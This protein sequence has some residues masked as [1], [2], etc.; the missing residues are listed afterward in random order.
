[1]LQNLTL[2]KSPVTQ[3]NYPPYFLLTPVMYSELNSNQI[4]SH[5]FLLSYLLSFSRSHVFRT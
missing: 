1:M 3:F 5:P 2:I 4:S